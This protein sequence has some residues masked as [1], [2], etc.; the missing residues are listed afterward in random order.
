VENA[1]YYTFSTIAQALAAAMA[2]LAA[3]AMYRLKT[4]DEESVGAA[5]LFEQETG[6]GGFSLKQYSLLS[7][8]EKCLEVMN[9]TIEKVGAGPGVVA[10]RD[11]LHQLQKTPRVRFAS[12]CGSPSQQ[13][14]L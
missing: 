1:L 9:E 6:I 10:L 7:H 11:Q 14:R 2:I 5:A 13:L 4:I 12:L 3:F 8:W